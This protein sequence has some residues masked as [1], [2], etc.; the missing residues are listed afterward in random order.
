MTDTD[1]IWGPVSKLTLGYHAGFAP[2]LRA[3]ALPGS[4][5]N[6]L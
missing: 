4:C 1:V 3:T 5:P 6:G 2:A